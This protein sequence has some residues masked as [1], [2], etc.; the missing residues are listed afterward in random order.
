VNISSI[1]A[2]KGVPSQVNYSA[3][4]AGILGLTRSLAREVAKFNINVNAVCPGYIETDMLNQMHPFVKSTM[5][6]YI[7]LG[8]VGK[9]EEVAGLVVYLASQE[10]SYITGQVFVVDGGLSL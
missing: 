6:R 9:P 2:L 3:A 4:K 1:S 7:P 8:R 5:T 10:T